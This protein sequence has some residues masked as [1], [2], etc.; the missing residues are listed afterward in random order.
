MVHFLDTNIFV[1]SF[2]DRDKRKQQRAR[3]L[4]V[5][6]L[7]SN[8]GLISFQV[9]QE[10]ISV[11][12]RK[13]ATPLTAQDC[14]RYL[15]EVLAPMCEVFPSIALYHQALDVHQRWQLSFY[16]ALIVAAALQG[17]CSVLYTEDL[18]HGLKIQALTV[19]NPF[20]AD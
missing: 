20:I 4:I 3:S 12:T 6:A 19:T 2:D 13:F 10:F 16:D 11:A 9:V 7:S 17:D 15:D 14:G 1:Y 8:D 5:D 18:H